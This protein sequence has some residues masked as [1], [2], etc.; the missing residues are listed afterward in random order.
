MT[1]IFRKRVRINASADELFRWH[2]QPGAFERLS[3][4]WEQVRVASRT[5]TIEEGGQVELK[6]RVGPVWTTWIAEHF[7]YIEGRQFRDRQASGPFAD[8]VHAHRIIAE[9]EDQSILE[10]EIE[11]RLPFGA[12]GRLLGSGFVR[13]K[14]EKTF[15][16]RHRI[17]EGDLEA[18]NRFQGQSK[19]KILVSGSSGLV[20]SSLVPFLTTGG[21]EVVR[22][23]R[24]QSNDGEQEISWDPSSGTID[25]AQL[26]GFDA[27]IHLAGEN[28]GD[29]RWTAARKTR[30][31]DSRIQG[32]RM[33]CEALASVSNPPK[34][35]VSASAIGIYGDRGGEVLDESS[36]PGTG[37]LADLCRDWEAAAD[38]ARERGI[39]VVHPRIGVVL[40]PAGGALAKMLLPFKLG[41]G[42]VIGS[43]SQYMSWIALDDLVGALHHI[44]GDESLQGP[45]NCVS[46]NAVTNREYTKVLGKVLSRPTVLP[47]PA[48]AM[49][50]AFG[51]LAKEL[52]LASAHVVPNRLQES[53][54]QFRFPDVEG[55]LRH[56]LGRG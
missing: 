47:M 23:V 41:I 5:G 7:D 49:K 54:Y 21:H 17:T 18:H 14:L 35:F 6:M 48:P 40:S 53:N 32:T 27:V 22:L 30:L 51:E 44:L 31:R 3:P 42:G 39:R 50:L 19:M 12:I 15:D 25:A 33:L 20:G 34:V 9:G 45:V 24:R 28:I 4:P 26:D 36:E 13:K 56:V 10:D 38:P 55:A 29:G 37:F 1:Q 11:Y 46:P 8:W 52:L 16:Y 43:G 2:V